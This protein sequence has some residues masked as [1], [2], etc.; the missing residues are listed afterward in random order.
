MKIILARKNK[1][2]QSKFSEKISKSS[3]RGSTAAYRPRSGLAYNG[4]LVIALT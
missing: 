4:S 1:H 2:Q 3:V